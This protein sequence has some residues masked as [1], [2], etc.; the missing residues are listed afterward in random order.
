M[1]ALAPTKPSTPRLS[2]F[3][4]K[5]SAPT[6]IVSTGWPQVEQTC[7][8]KLGITFDPWQDAAGRLILA[9]RASG[10]LAAMIDGVGMSV[11]RQ[12]GKTFLVG[13]MIFALCVDMP[14]LLLIWSAHHAR[15]HGETFLSL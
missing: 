7:R 14:G 5:V 8:V 2:E 1:T 13:G 12:V 9:K 6:G 4:R 3:A 15:T 10:K 11:P